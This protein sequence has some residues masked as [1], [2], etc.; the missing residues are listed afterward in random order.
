MLELKGKYCK[1]C[2]ILTDNIEQ[3]ALSMVYH[4]LD[5]PMF[6]GAKI[7]I[8]PDVHAGK[9]IVVGFT[10]PFTDHV[11][12]DH[13]GG[14]IG[15][16]VST[17]ITDLPVCAENYPAIEKSIRENVKF[18]MS[19]QQKPI[20]PTADL[21][22]H[23]QLRLQQARQ[24]WPEM[25]GTMNVSEK[26][27]TAMLKRI[28]QKEQMFYNSIGSVG[29]GNHFVEVGVTP[30]G[31]YAFTVHCGSRNLGQKV[32]KYW[33]ME[34]GKQ[35]G[36]VNGFLV[37]D[38]MKGYITDMVVAQAY[39][40][41]NHTIISRLVSESISKESGCKARI[42]EQI[43]T[44]HNYIDF[45]MKMM[46]KGAVA[47]PAGRKLVIPFNMRDG[48]II[49]HGKGNEDWNRSAPH[50]AG[51]LLSRSDAKESIDLEEF[52][53]SMKGIYSTSVGTGTI[54][55]S[56]MA[57]KDPKEILRLIEDTVEVEYFIRPVI[58]LKA[59]NSYDS[60]VEIDMNE[61]SD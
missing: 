6:E 60:N 48:L 7:R 56:P 25:V 42:V 39:A 8:M 2:K 28:N 44:T 17:T 40:E 15:C 12:P 32:W 51:R 55:E 3:E 1:D 16:S 52:R 45:S 10:V 41:F 5:N 57:Y 29:G 14:D 22:K 33:K 47:A 53:K 37:G 30:E 49:A 54:D 18:G 59:T 38:A 24:Q 27:I 23:L 11:N 34:A 13:V 19:I 35:T 50:G 43:Y 61:E 36:V 21:Y 26:G 4:F 58:N 31:N 46:R 20:Y 9:D